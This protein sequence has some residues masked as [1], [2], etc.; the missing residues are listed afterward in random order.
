MKTLD[1]ILLKFDPYIGINNVNRTRIARLNLLNESLWVLLPKQLTQRHLMTL[2]G[3]RNFGMWYSAAPSAQER[4]PQTSL[5]TWLRGQIYYKGVLFLSIYGG[6]LFLRWCHQQDWRDR[7]AVIVNGEKL[8]DVATWWVCR[9]HNW[10]DAWWRG[11]AAWVCRQHDWR[12]LPHCATIA[13]YET[14]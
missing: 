9:Q 12:S 1:L 14:A 5:P 7:C 10:R 8:H 3:F 6:G 2:L 4:D 11:C 13:S